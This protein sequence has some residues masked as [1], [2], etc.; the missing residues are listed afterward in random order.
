MKEAELQETWKSYFASKTAGKPDLLLEKKIVEHYYPLVKKIA[1]RLHQK[2]IEV[3]ADE[4]A[5]MGIEGLYDAVANYDSDRNTKFETYSTPRIRG[6]M[7]DEIR[8]CDWVPRLVRSRAAKL[9]RQRQRLESAAGRKLLHSELAEKFG[10][11]TEAFEEFVVGATNPAVHSVNDI[12]NNN[13]D[14]DRSLSIEHV[15]DSKAVDPSHKILRRELFDK[16]M[17]RNFTE[18]ERKIMRLYY[19]GELSMKEISEKVELS[20]SRVSQMHS[21]IVKRLRQKAERNPEYFSDILLLAGKFK[22]T[23][24]A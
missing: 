1:N 6:S 19:Y 21:I 18:Q 7:L 22:D 2:L 4:L 10:M 23:V 20:E 12:P 9:D 17:G 15:S 8:K 11:T 14:S 16:L 3:Q 5:S 24:A 13:S